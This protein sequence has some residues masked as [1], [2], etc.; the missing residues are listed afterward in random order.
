[1]TIATDGNLQSVLVG[2]THY[3]DTVLH[4]ARLEDG[5]G[6]AMKHVA[7]IGGNDSARRLIEEQR[8]MELRQLI[9]RTRTG[10]CLRNP[11]TLVGTETN[12]GSAEGELGEMASRELVIHGDLL[13]EH[14]KEGSGLLG[15]TGA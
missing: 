6:Y 11:R 15:I 4:G 9:K 12:N 7:L 14:A 8:T 10:A 1:M 3:R 5:C 13:T 2:V